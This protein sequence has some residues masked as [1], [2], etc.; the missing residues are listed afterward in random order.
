MKQTVRFVRHQHQ[1]RPLAKSCQS[2]A[3]WISRTIQQN[4]ER[5]KLRALRHRSRSTPFSNLLDDSKSSTTR[6]IT[7]LVCWRDFQVDSSF[8]ST[9]LH[10]TPY[11]TVQH[12]NSSCLRFDER[13]NYINAC[14][15]AYK[16][17]KNLNSHLTSWNCD[18]WFRTSIST[19]LQKNLSRCQSA[20][21]SLPSQHNTFVAEF[22]RFQDSQIATQ[23]MRNFL[24]EFVILQPS[25]SFQLLTSSKHSNNSSIRRS[26]KITKMVI[27]E[28]V[29]YFELITRLDDQLVQEKEVHP[30]FRSHSG[31]FTIRL[32]MICLAQTTQWKDGIVDFR[33][34][35]VPTIQQSAR[36]L[37]W[38]KDGTKHERDETGAI[39][40]WPTTSTIKEVISRHGSR[41]KEVR[42]W[43]WDTDQMST[44]S[45][46]L[47]TTLVYKSYL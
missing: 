4:V 28:L 31:M 6:R 42:F 2:R 22:S 7:T 27:H 21:M 23:L 10:D 45:V 26:S 39:S 1:S 46:E 17:I 40:G 43:I 19:K 9:D 3:T 32:F 18:D 33:S 20:R 16:I 44:I 12:R 11:W 47:R 41:H 34:S 25:L 36:F 14:Y 15:S 30:F 24:L 37:L 38:S 8:D 13:H 5:R 29:D 35:L